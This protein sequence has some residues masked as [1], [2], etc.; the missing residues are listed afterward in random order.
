VLAKQPGDRYQTVTDLARAF[1]QAASLATGALVVECVDALD[2][3]PVA[4]AV[5]YLNGRHAGLSDELGQWRQEQPREEVTLSAKLER[6]AKGDLVVVCNV[7]GAE[8]ELDGVRSGVIGAGG[9]CYLNAL[10]AGQHTIVITHPKHLPEK[11]SVEIKTWES[12][13]LQLQLT[14]RVRFKVFRELAENIRAL[15]KRPRS[16]AE[17]ASAQVECGA[18]GTKLDVELNYCVECG[19]PLRQPAAPP[20][21]A[22]RNDRT[23]S[24]ADR[25]A[26]VRTTQPFPPGYGVRADA[27]VENDDSLAKS[28]N[29]RSYRSSPPQRSRS[30]RRLWWVGGLLAA[31]VLTGLGLWQLLRAPS[32]LPPPPPPPED[33]TS[34]P[35]PTPQPTLAPPEEMVFVP[36]GEFKLGRDGGNP[37]EAPAHRVI[38]KSF[39]LDRTE[40]TNAQYQKFIDETNHLAPR[41]WRGGLYPLG[42]ADLPVTD[43]TWEDARDYAKWAGKRLPTEEEWEFAT[44]GE[45]GWRYSWGNAWSPEKAN[46]GR[47][48]NRPT[49]VGQ[50]P[51]G[52]PLGVF[53]L[54]GNVWEWT[55]SDCAPY[56]QGRGQ[57]CRLDY[58]N[59]KIMRGGAYD[60]KPGNATATFRYPYPATRGDWGKYSREADYKRV[61]FRCAKDLSAQ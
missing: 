61:G 54:I 4:G 31:A 33:I 56:P 49:P 28:G 59:L 9:R 13:Q 60:S 22:G 15:M 7:E 8:V 21:D 51:Q 38:V 57:P 29:A 18:C 30:G 6:E 10:D 40:V 27:T 41:A 39:F 58:T 19:A 3:R 14:P 16:K 55:S 43:V 12:S 32:S 52:A 36:G 24:L 1:R 17:P 48:N 5:V 2:E 42:Q 25:D 35:E 20:S 46:A 47:R 53:D 45:R 11:S 23:P 37:A 50:Y 44:R 26:P 34:T